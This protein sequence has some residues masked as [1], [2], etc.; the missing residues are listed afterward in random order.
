MNNDPRFIVTERL[1][2]NAD[3]SPATLH[4]TACHY[5]NPVR[6]DRNPWPR[7]EVTPAEAR[8]HPEWLRCPSCQPD[9]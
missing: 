8:Q 4:T 5:A 2:P 6:T 3:G 7:R 9:V 1:A